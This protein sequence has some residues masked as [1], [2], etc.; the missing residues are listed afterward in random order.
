M[1][2]NEICRYNSAPNGGHLHQLRTNSRQFHRPHCDKSLKQ[3]SR[4]QTIKIFVDIGYSTN[5]N[6]QIPQAPCVSAGD[7][8]VFFGEFEGDGFEAPTSRSICHG[9]TI[10]WPDKL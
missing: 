6:T 9:A 1:M 3:H 5:E 2:Q 4:L 10:L 7:C 8:V